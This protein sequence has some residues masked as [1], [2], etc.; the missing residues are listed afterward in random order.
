MIFCVLTASQHEDQFAAS[1]GYGD[2]QERLVPQG[3]HM[4]CLAP[5]KSIDTLISVDLNEF[6]PN[7]AVYGQHMLCLAHDGKQG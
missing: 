1:G 2:P 7:S 5:M 6:I 4:L 3:Q